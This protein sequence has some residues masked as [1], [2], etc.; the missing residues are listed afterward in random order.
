MKYPC[1]KLASL[2]PTPVPTT[3]SELTDRKWVWVATFALPIGSVLLLLL[4]YAN[5]N[6]FYC[7][8]VVDSNTARGRKRSLCGCCAR[9]QHPLGGSSVFPLNNCT[10]NGYT[11]RC[12]SSRVMTVVPSS[13]T[14]HH[15]FL[16]PSPSIPMVQLA[17]R[18]PHVPGS[19]GG[20]RLDGRTAAPAEVTLAEVPGAND[21]ILVCTMDGKPVTTPT[22]LAV[23][24]VGG[25][26]VGLDTVHH[27]H[28]YHHHRQ[29]A[30]HNGGGAGMWVPRDPMDDTVISAGAAAAGLPPT[31]H[32]QIS[33]PVM[34]L[35]PRSQPSQ[36]VLRECEAGEGSVWGG[37]KGGH[38]KQGRR[39]EDQ[40]RL[41]S[42][43]CLS[44]ASSS[45]FPY[46]L[47]PAVAKAAA[48]AA[49]ASLVTASAS[50]QLS[51]SLGSG[52]RTA[53]EKLLVDLQ[54]GAVSGMGGFWERH[55]DPLSGRPYF[56]HL[57]TG[58]VIWGGADGASDAGGRGAGK[59]APCKGRGTG[60]PVSSIPLVLPTVPPSLHPM[61]HPMAHLTPSRLSICRTRGL[62]S[63]GQLIFNVVE[64]KSGGRE[65]HKQDARGITSR[66]A[67]EVAAAAAARAVRA[68][69]ETEREDEPAEDRERRRQ[70]EEDSDIC[71]TEI[72]G[73]H[74]RRYT[75]Q[76]R[77]V[78]EG[79]VVSGFTRT[80]T[81]KAIREAAAA[82]AAA[83]GAAAG[84]G[85][86]CVGSQSNNGYFPNSGE[87]GN[88]ADEPR[89]TAP[90]LRSVD[91]RSSYTSA[92]TSRMKVPKPCAPGEKSQASKVAAL[93]L[94]QQQI[95]EG[96]SHE[97]RTFFGTY[98]LRPPRPRIKHLKLATAAFADPEAPR[99]GGWRMAARGARR[100]SQL[101]TGAFP[102][103]RRGGPMAKIRHSG[104]GSAAVLG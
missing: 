24:S 28:Y 67:L 9:S 35:A 37:G 60:P 75:R 51:Q 65:T 42:S 99:V 15:D 83:T 4:I 76:G 61:A 78:S 3:S 13:G 23:G 31:Q 45:L 54:G 93:A 73:R 8:R 104:D 39:K 53:T 27:H 103:A 52:R 40:T 94:R 29:Q 10:C 49:A 80:P 98:Q 96:T 92:F 11:C 41:S 85:T 20:R 88:D 2:S 97:R 43:P 71:L 26:S 5:R 90:P 36:L 57:K 32:P 74:S 79:R 64:Q 14:R 70:R 34:P 72:I 22:A 55:Q 69:S 100:M 46:M 86:T 48:A 81:S 77:I 95:R 63:S 7:G 50:A 12:D 1:Y 44:G 84:L 25:E 87:G 68:T 66:S 30:R 19:A 82:T 33:T 62:T 18:S 38:Q 6:C 102:K 59:G 21:R 17:R 89:R 58:C 56:K 91:R 101:E 16:T 47:P